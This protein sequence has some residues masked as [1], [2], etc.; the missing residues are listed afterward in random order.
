MSNQ[1]SSMT[2]H[3]VKLPHQ[4]LKQQ[5]WTST[6]EHC[7]HHGL[8]VAEELVLMDDRTG[9]SRESKENSTPQSWKG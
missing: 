1:F 3:V 9:T 7:E 2:V 6:E 5:A 4:D 8:N